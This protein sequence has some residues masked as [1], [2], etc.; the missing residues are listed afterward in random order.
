MENLSVKPANLTQHIFSHHRAP[1]F[2]VSR[3]SNKASAI[4]INA[5]NTMDG[6][7]LLNLLEDEVITAC[8]FDPQYRGIMDKMNY[9]NEG[10]RQ[11]GRCQ[12][13]QMDGDI[14]IK[15]VQEISRVLV[16]SGHLF[17]WVDKFHLC[18]GIKSWLRN[19][20]LSVVDL[21]TWDKGRMG[22]GYR[23]R[24]QSE[25]CM[26]I[27]KKPIRVKGIWIKHNIPDTWREKIV[28]K[29]H[30][31]QKPLDL[32][33]ALIEAVSDKHDFI[34]DPCAG[35]YTTLK[36]CA[37]AGRQFIGSDIAYYPL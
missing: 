8:F 17:L 1:S 20:A 31:H 16:K 12:L 27:Q 4:K 34:L 3:V 21:I 28:T 35:S 14:I 10:K 5:P 33:K 13:Q 29:K 30:P 24:R 19:T 32:Q 6:L 11:Q 22:M 36:A 23:T 18:E 7:S 26:I 9:G 37:I 25:Y 2:A 15:F